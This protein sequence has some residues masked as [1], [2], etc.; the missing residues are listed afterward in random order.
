MADR[1]SKKGSKGKLSHQGALKAF[2]VLRISEGF[3]QCV[4]VHRAQFHPS[5]PYPTRLMSSPEPLQ[6]PAQ[7]WPHIAPRA[8]AQGSASCST[9]TSQ[10]HMG[11][12]ARSLPNPD[13]YLLPCRLVELLSSIKAQLLSSRCK[14]CLP[15]LICL[16]TSCMAGSHLSHVLC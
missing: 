12:T 15:S 16:L 6:S 5:F 4:W 14:H 8:Q 2:S 13:K 10:R 1:E 9:G 3:G 7:W 11:V